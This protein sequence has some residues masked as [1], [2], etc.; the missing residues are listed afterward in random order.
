MY[1]SAQ[2]ERS[3][4]LEQQFID[5]HRTRLKAKTLTSITELEKRMR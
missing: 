3:K 2:D 1:E 4:M 5:G